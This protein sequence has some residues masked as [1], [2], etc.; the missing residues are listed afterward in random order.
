[1]RLFRRAWL[2][3]LWAHCLAFAG[4]LVVVAP[5]L[6]ID[7][8]FTIDE[9]AY[10][11]QVRA[12]DRGGWAYEYAGEE[13]DSELE[14]LPLYNPTRGEDG[15]Y[16]YVKHPFYPVAQLGASRL[17]GDVVGV[18]LWALLGAL[19]VAVAAWLV[20]GEIEPS[21]RRAAF[22]VAAAAPVL[23]NAY[24]VWAHAPSAALAGFAV[25]A[26]LRAARALQWRWALLLAACL[27]VGVLIRAEMLLFALAL[28]GAM[29]VGLWRRGLAWAAG[30]PVLCAAAGAGAVLVESRW[31]RSIVGRSSSVAGFRGEDG[32]PFAG[33]GGLS[34]LTRWVEGRAEGAWNSL[35]QGSLGEQR[36][37][38]LV[39]GGM[40][41]VLFGAWVARRR[42]PNW[43]RD[44]LVAMAVATLLY[45]LR[46]RSDATQPITGF[47][48]AWPLALLGLVLV[49]RE[50]LRKAHVLVVSVG[51]FSLAVLATQYR[52]GGGREWGGRFFFPM[53]VPVAVLACLGLRHGLAS[54]RADR[55]AWK[56]LAGLGVLLAV[57][58]TVAGFRVLHTSRTQVGAILRE[59]AGGEP[60]LIMTHVSGLPPFAWQEYPEVGWLAV[61][62]RE[63]AEVAARLRA[64]GVE[65]LLLLGPKTTEPTDVPTYTA[66]DVTGPE[67][68]R[69]GWRTFRLRAP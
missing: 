40:V 54:A 46:L 29:A 34:S 36:A 16:P 9:G 68:D 26:G 12:L 59:V 45:A 33:S 28:A 39:A 20:A 48:A 32:S 52:I 24:I 42:R 22:W 60:T 31:R 17:V 5:L 30:V 23:V 49:P 44:T 13:V 61:P 3:P 58:P 64:A 67:A 37:A 43:Q 35:F 66:E 7:E 69:R 62:P 47:L 21:A 15:A 50:H 6:R 8:A 57:L 38:L 2:L 53:V 4:L 14:W 63:F 27:G 10:G 51:L 56:A 41:M 19:G 11:I 1:M 65:D 18:H 25:L 55:A